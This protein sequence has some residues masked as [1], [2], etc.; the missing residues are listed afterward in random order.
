MEFYHGTTLSSARGIIKNGFRPRGGAIW[1]TTSRGYAKNRAE[2]KARRR[3]G[4]PVIIQ[5][6]LDVDDFRRSLGPGRVHARGG[7]IAVHES[8]DVQILESNFF[9]VAGV[10]SRACRVG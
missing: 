10:S 8:L 4:R 9:R 3:H 2:Q 5:T 6:E 1:F 7:I